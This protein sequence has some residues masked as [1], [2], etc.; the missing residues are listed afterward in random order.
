[1]ERS[2]DVEWRQK[3]M[4]YYEGIIA[5][6]NIGKVIERYAAKAKM[7]LGIM[8]CQGLGT[9]RDAK[10]GTQ[11]IREADSFSKGF[12]KVGFKTL[13]LLAEIFGQGYAQEGGEPS[14]DDL[15]QA[16]AYQK[17][18]VDQFNPE[19]DDRNNRGYLELAKEYLKAIEERKAIQER[20][21]DDASYF[22]INSTTGVNPEF[23]EMQKMMM[24]VSPEARKRIDADKAALERL[25]QRFIQEG[26]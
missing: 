26:W 20:L 25:R 24:E 8:L 2:F 21:K 10:R 9:R 11:L 12:S 15:R 18:A 1:M 7:Y 23:K 13:E 16:I 4:R 6:F 14:I 3:A 17:K 19:K 5:D 22:G